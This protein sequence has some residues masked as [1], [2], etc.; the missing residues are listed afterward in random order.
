MKN[1]FFA[2]LFF[3]TLIS[4]QHSNSVKNSPTPSSEKITCTLNKDT[5]LIEI[6]PFQK[7]GCDVQYTKFAMAKSVAKA[8]S[9]KKYCV[10]VRQR[11]VTHLTNSGFICE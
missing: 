5:R 7:K 9:E 3:T 1:I 6:L 10:E 11:I 8:Q 2:F 4:C